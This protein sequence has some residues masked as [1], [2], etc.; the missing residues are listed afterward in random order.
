MALAV[1]PFPVPY[2][3]TICRALAS[4]CALVN[5]T[6][7]STSA[8]SGATLL[9][10]T[11]TFNSRVVRLEH[12][13]R[14]EERAQMIMVALSPAGRMH[15][16]V[17]AADQ[18]DAPFRRI[19]QIV[20]PGFPAGLCC[21]TLYELP[22][23]V[24]Q[25][26][27]G[28]LLW[29]ASVG[30]KPKD[31][32]MAITIY[33]SGDEGRTWS[34]LSEIRSPNQ[35]GLWEPEFTVDREGA[36]VLFFSDETDPAE[37]SQTLK[38][39]RTYDGV[40]WRDM[41]YVVASKIQRDRPGMAVTRRLADGRWMMTYELGGPAHFIVYY[42]LSDDGWNWGNP[43]N[44]GSDIRLP[45]GAF[46]AHTPRFTVMPDGAILLTAQL[47]ETPE[48][49]LGARNGR[50]LLVNR[51]GNPTELWRT[52]PAPVPVPGACSETC[53][54]QNW[55]PNYSSALLP[56]RDGRQ[57]LEFASEW[58]DRGCLT[59]YAWASWSPQEVSRPEEPQ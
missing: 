50:I 18:D 19:G 46:P 2:G 55:C 53:R 37:H 56:S 39:V 29:A 22:Q 11:P 9:N 38:K 10:P 30:Q 25:L 28:T 23:Q 20:D 51:S 6:A 40:N 58:T 35:G 41:G 4:L 52:I 21:G 15:A 33:R 14:L 12:A 34:Y 26:E 57:V 16:E 48:L 3:Q 59:S 8:A 27:K 5:L 1:F 36:L 32:H 7:I 42:K 24:G 13:P 49:R 31:R 44:V 47:I 17:Y 43:T 54:T 45:N